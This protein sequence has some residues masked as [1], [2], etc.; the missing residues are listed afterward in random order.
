MRAPPPAPAQEKLLAAAPK[1]EPKRLLYGTS[2]M[3]KRTAIPSS[4]VTQY[5]TNA[6]AA[7]RRK[8][9][10]TE[11]KRSGL[12][13]RRRLEGMA[14]AARNVAPKERVTLHKRPSWAEGID[15]EGKALQCDATRLG[16]AVGESQPWRAEHDCSLYRLVLEVHGA[17]SASLQ[18]FFP[19][20]NP[21]SQNAW[22]GLFKADH[23]VW[24][25]ERGDVGCGGHKMAWRCIT[26]DKQYGMMKFTKLFGGSAAVDDGEYVFTLQPD[27]GTV[28]KAVSERFRVRDRQIVAVIS[29]SALVSDSGLAI[30]RHARQQSASLGLITVASAAPAADA[31]VEDERCYFPVHS[32]NVNLGENYVATQPLLKDVYRIVDK[33]SFLDW[34]LTSDYLG[35]DVEA[36]AE[37]E[38]HRLRKKGGPGGAAEQAAAQP[39][40]AGSSQYSAALPSA[41]QHATRKGIGGSGGA[42]VRGL[43]GGT[44]GSEGYGEATMASAHKIGVL[45]QSLRQLVLH[46]LCPH[47][48]WGLLW[49]LGPHSTFLDIGAGYGKVVMHLRLLAGMR[50]AVGVEC[51][52]SRV[53]IANKALYAVETE[54]PNV[55]A[56]RKDAKDVKPRAPRAL[57]PFQKKPKPLTKAAK[58]EAAMAE[59]DQPAADAADAADAAE[60]EAEP[61]EAEP[62]PK[63]EDDAA[64]AASSAS[65]DAAPQ[66]ED[67]PPAAPPAA[68]P[69]PPSG[70]PW[71]A[72][73]PFAGVEFE[74][75]DATKAEALNY[76]HIYIFDWVFSKHTLH[77]VAEVLQRS[78]F[79]VMMSTHKPA[80]WWSYGLV[81]A[82]PVAK[83]SGFRTTG[84]E[85]M[86][87]YVYINLEKVP[88]GAM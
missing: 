14:A 39:S 21:G 35:G 48:H 67:A 88:Q 78:P 4:T 59:A 26:A 16:P 6:K 83:L 40:V 17:D 11:L 46:D 56:P 57:K 84:G 18:W 75:S 51:V 64:S 31:E 30:H 25:D 66:P 37:A 20:A 50:R 81:K 87:L 58:A 33:E 61:M 65:T 80:E 5:A 27:Y 23:V 76:S 53:V 2:D 47:L 52:A 71:L 38:K 3:P 41:A 73:E 42:I 55:H 12:L 79:Y 7:A 34:G 45:L 43:G 36:D 54:S 49:D 22:I 28:C 62:A 72:A 60:P 8:R 69:P 68:P 19:P 86:T 9:K 77:A 13:E 32:V 44:L 10:H 63:P 70:I 1:E 74:H 82:Q 85:G 15:R 29:D 24:G